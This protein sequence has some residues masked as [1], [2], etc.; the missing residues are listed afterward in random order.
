[1]PDHS[2]D[3]YQID[4][5]S[6]L[7]GTVNY[8]N[9]HIIVCSGRSDWAAKIEDDGGFVKTLAGVIGKE[10]GNDAIKLTACDLPGI[11]QG[12]TVLIFPDRVCIRGLSESTIPNL[13]HYV[14]QGSN[15]GLKIEPFAQ[16]LILVCR[17]EKRDVRCGLAGP[18]IIQKMEAILAHKGLSEQV[19]VAGSSHLGGHKFAGVAV[20]YPSGNWYGRLTA[21]DALQIIEAECV[22]HQP[23]PALWRGRMG[24]STENQVNVANA[25]GWIV[26]E[27][28]SAR[29]DS[30]GKS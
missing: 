30:L 19:V 17:H 23:Y 26:V 14:Q 8:Y 27:D 12:E 24:L 5:L 22:H 4:R 25:A 28:Q 29:D 16:Q 2:F 13:I 7:P 15:Q 18:G 11:G 3:P 21:P 20:V 1:M 9:R 10:A 6:R